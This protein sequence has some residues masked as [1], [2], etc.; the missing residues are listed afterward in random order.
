MNNKT[1]NCT[2]T[3]C[4]DC[5]HEEYRVCIP[6]TSGLYPNFDYHCL[7]TVKHSAL[8]KWNC[9]TGCEEDIGIDES[10]L[11]SLVAPRGKPCLNFKERFPSP[12]PP[13]LSHRQRVKNWFISLTE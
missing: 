11:C 1:R 4:K 9:R 10:E 6:I 8:W 3:P 5:L 13:P 2:G 7:A 12:E